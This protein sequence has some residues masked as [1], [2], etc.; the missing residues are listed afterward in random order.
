MSDPVVV[1]AVYE[2]GVLKPSQP[3]DL[4]EQQVVQISLNPEITTDHPYITQTPGV[5]GGR[6]VVRGTRIPVK[7]LVGY[8][9]LNYKETEI[10]AGFPDL[11]AAQLYDALSYYYDHQAEIDADIE[12]DELSEVLNKFNLEINADGVL[13]PKS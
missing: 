3:L 8:Y 9:R 5:C 13:S 1:Q 11:T 2:K 6:P 4:A 12:A 7:V 10:L